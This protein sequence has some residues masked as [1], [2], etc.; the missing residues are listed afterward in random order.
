MRYSSDE[1]MIL[2]DGLEPKRF[3]EVMDSEEKKKMDGCN[4]G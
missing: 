4:E 1:Y 2:K 3:R